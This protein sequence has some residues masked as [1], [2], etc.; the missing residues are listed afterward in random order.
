MRFVHITNNNIT[1]QL[2]LL[3][4]NSAVCATPQ[5][6]SHAIFET[7]YPDGRTSAQHSQAAGIL[8]GLFFGPL[9]AWDK[10]QWAILSS[11]DESLK[12]AT[13]LCWFFFDEKRLFS[14]CVVMELC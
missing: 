14:A 1:Y 2:G 8:C 13:E 11:Q 7:G 12:A 4:F 5:S 6:G 9:A 3:S 10:R